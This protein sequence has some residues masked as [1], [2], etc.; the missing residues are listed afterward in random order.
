MKSE[1]EVFR[2]GGG[3]EELAGYSRAVRNG[4]GVSVSGTAPESRGEMTFRPLP[5]E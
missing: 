3:A 2:T 5:G 1:R 4:P